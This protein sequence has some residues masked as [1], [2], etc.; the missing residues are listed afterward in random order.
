MKNTK[1]ILCLLFALIALTLVMS[2]SVFA[3]ETTSRVVEVSTAAELKT[4][5][6]CG[7]NNNITPKAPDGS[8]INDGDT[9]RLMADIGYDNKLTGLIYVKRNVTIDLNGHTLTTEGPRSVIMLMNGSITSS[10]G[11]ANWVY[12]GTN[13]ALRV[14]GNVSL[15]ENINIVCY[16]RSGNTGDAAAGISILSSGTAGY[17][18]GHVDTIKNVQMSGEALK[19]GLEVSTTVNTVSGITVTNATQYGIWAKGDCGTLTGCDISGAKAVYVNANNVSIELK[20]CTLKGDN[21]IFDLA[22]NGANIVVDKATT[23]KITITGTD[24]VVFTGSGVASNFD[25]PGYTYVDGVIR[26]VGE[27]SYVEKTTL[28]TCTTVGS[29]VNKCEIINI[30]LI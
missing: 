16:R 3:E 6:E 9:I 2:I 25:V 24:G 11:I 14:Y 29:V 1:K 8:V 17:G 19:V 28:P 5:I 26:C 21:A 4:A 30:S 12:Y 15:I 22:N 18:V 7:Q 20:N 13:N 10:N 27:H 23:E